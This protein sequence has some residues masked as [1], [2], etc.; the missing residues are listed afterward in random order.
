M[1]LLLATSERDRSRQKSLA[2]QLPAVER[3]K[4]SDTVLVIIRHGDRWDYAQPEWRDWVKAAGLQCIHD[5]PLSPLGQEQ[6]QQT[7][8]HLSSADVLGGGR[9]FDAI[10]SSPY[11]HAYHAAA[12]SLGQYAHSC[13]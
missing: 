6:A 7:A 8:A 12:V 10:L 4:M 11:Y 1:H 2:R 5:P 9:K 13:G 3:R